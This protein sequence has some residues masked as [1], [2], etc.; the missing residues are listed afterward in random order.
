MKITVIAIGQQKKD[1]AIQTSC[2]SFKR[3]SKIQVNFLILLETSV[4]Y[5]KFPASSKNHTVTEK[6]LKTDTAKHLNKNIIDF[7]IDQ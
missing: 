7:S 3:T 4:G 6:P 1:I 2:N 5:C